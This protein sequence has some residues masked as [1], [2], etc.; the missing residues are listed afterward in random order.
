MLSCTTPAVSATPLTTQWP[1]SL[2]ESQSAYWTMVSPSAS[3]TLNRLAGA[4]LWLC[5]ALI[6]T[7]GETGDTIGA[8]LANGLAL[9]LPQV[10]HKSPSNTLMETASAAEPNT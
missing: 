6:A 4:K 8:W 2:P 1:P 7:L 10:L 5:V 9:K 3:L